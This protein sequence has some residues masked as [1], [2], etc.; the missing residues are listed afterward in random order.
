MSPDN[1][2]TYIPLN[3][4]ATRYGVNVAML[5][6]AVESGIMQAV[7]T[8]EGK[9]LVESEDVRMITERNTLWDRVKHL[10]GNSIGLEEACRK[11]RLS[12]TS[13]YR[14]IGQGY[15]RVL[16]DQ[17]GGGRGRKRTLNEADV[18]YASLVAETRGRQQGKRIF[19][20]EFIPLHLAA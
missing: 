15:V 11:Y 8:P 18:A 7:R 3:Q 19:T 2:P 12:T 9:I 6:R 5:H 16:S 10:D 14:W 13:V 4:A 1:L 17:R 20:R